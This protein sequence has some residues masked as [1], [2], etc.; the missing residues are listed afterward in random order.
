MFTDGGEGVTPSRPGTTERPRVSRV[1]LPWSYRDISGTAEEFTQKL[2]EVRRHLQLLVNFHLA[3]WAQ[4]N[5]EPRPTSVALES[6]T[7]L[8]Q[9]LHFCR[10]PGY[11]WD[12]APLFNCATILSFVGC[13]FC[14]FTCTCKEK[15]SCQ[16]S[17]E[18]QH[19]VGLR[20]QP[21]AA[22]ALIKASAARRCH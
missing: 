13:L 4:R 16:V 19:F 7:Y 5:K 15:S 14:F 3:D 22:A 21:G 12:S 17:G 9:K 2:I 11:W 8:G 18:I 6:T 1:L 20:H 10:S